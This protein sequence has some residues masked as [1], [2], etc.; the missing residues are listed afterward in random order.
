MRA[1]PYVSARRCSRLARRTF[2]RARFLRAGFKRLI[3]YNDFEH[4]PVCAPAAASDDHG[5]RR[6]VRRSGACAISARGDLPGGGG[7]FGG[8]DAKVIKVSSMQMV[9]PPAPR[10]PPAVVRSLPG[11][12]SASPGTALRE[13]DDN[14]MA[15]PWCGCRKHRAAQ[16]TTSS[17]LSA[18]ANSRTPA[19]LGCHKGSGNLVGSRS[20][21][22]THLWFEVLVRL[23][24][25]RTGSSLLRRACATHAPRCET[26]PS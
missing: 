20:P 22:V 13:R 23:E 1:G 19:T 7:P 18:G 21:K 12:A 10:A 5:S 9:L 6:G 11:L 17:R 24:P 15:Q 26:A 16:R 14:L 3:R 8:I 4:D 25:A 2:S